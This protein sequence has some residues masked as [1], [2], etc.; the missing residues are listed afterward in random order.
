M[1]DIDDFDFFNDTRVSNP[2]NFS[3]ASALFCGSQ[4]TQA[5]AASVPLCPPSDQEELLPPSGPVLTARPHSRTIRMFNE[6]M[7]QP[8]NHVPGDEPTTPKR[9]VNTYRGKDPIKKIVQNKKLQAIFA[10]KPIPGMR[11]K[12][13]DERVELRMGVS[14]VL[15]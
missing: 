11:K 4:P 13:P 10:D 5:P 8:A 14:R 1:N 9:P 12:H 15:K 2:T 7:N 6:P 3:Q